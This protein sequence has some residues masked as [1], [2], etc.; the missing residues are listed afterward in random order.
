MLRIFG[1]ARAVLSE[2]VKMSKKAAD[3]RAFLRFAVDVLLYRVLR[4]V[5]LPSVNSERQIRLRGGV[6]ITYRLNRGDIQPIREAWL[7]EVYQLPFTAKKSDVL[8]DLGANIG[9][10]SVW[11]TKRYGYSTIIAV[12][13]SP[14]NARL[15]QT[16]LENNGIAAEVVEAAVGPTD[17][18]VFFEENEEANLGR[19]GS[20][21]RPVPMLAMQS[22]LRKLP[23]A[24]SVDLVK[25]D[26]EGGEEALLEGKLSW[27]ECV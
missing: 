6:R 7:D 13:P 25:L 10:T 22:V 12:E 9:L 11:L 26:I 14:S 3:T 19:V 5:R 1:T 4:L 24:I 2:L 17:S 15:A 23:V 16:N 27:L 20:E 21:G 8:I 18:M